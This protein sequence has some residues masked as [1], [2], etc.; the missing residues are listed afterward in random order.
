M[1]KAKQYIRYS[2]GEICFAIVLSITTRRLTNASSF[3]NLSKHADTDELDR[4]KTWAN[5]ACQPVEDIL[6]VDPNTEENSSSQSKLSHTTSSL[7]EL[8]SSPESPTAVGGGNFCGSQNIVPGRPLH[9]ESVPCVK[10]WVF[11]RGRKSVSGSNNKQSFK[12]AALPVLED[13]EVYPN[14]ENLPIDFQ[15]DWCEISDYV[16]ET[17]G[18]SFT[19]DFGSIASMVEHG[20]ANDKDSIHRKRSSLSP[21]S[22]T[23]IALSK[24]PSSLSS[25]ASSEDSSL[26][27]EFII[28]RSA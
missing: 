10:A 3:P 23:T 26:C 9:S 15:I 13:V 12:L 14:C 1:A 8:S 24:E 20:I 16:H 4:P 5:K 25:R 6:G 17:P 2:G 22:Q 19:V 27:S 28:N 21:E 18:A 7:S 11:K